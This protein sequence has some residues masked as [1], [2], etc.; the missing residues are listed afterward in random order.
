MLIA[1]NSGGRA[2]LVGVTVSSPGSDALL[3]GS[4]RYKLTL[5]EGNSG[6]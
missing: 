4:T 3:N 2:T 5:G 1:Q 6:W